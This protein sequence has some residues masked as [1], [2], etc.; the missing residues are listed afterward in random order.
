MTPKLTVAQHRRRFRM[1]TGVVLVIGVLG[2]AT[3]AL[4][5]NETIDLH[6]WGIYVALAAAVFSALAGLAFAFTMAAIESRGDYSE[7]AASSTAETG[8][9]MATSSASSFGVKVS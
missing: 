7:P 1:T 2:V 9:R 6:P 8:S 4:A 5:R 3:I